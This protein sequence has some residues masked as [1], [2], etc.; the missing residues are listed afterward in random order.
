M[1]NLLLFLRLQHVTFIWTLHHTMTPPS[2]YND[3]ELSEIRR[4]FPVFDEH[5]FLNAASMTPLPSPSRD[6]VI[7]YM[8]DHSK[9]GFKAAME[10]FPLLGD[11]R[12]RAAALLGASRDEITFVRNTSDG[13][14]LV[15]FGLSFAPGDQV[16]INDQEFPSNVYPWLAL[17]EKGVE[18]V[19]VKSEE[20]RVTPEMIEAAM[21]EK[22]RLVAISSVQF[23]SGYRADLAAISR[24]CRQNN[25]Y[26]F[27][28]A[29][30]SLGLIPLDAQALGVDFLSAGAHK[31]LCGLEGA[32]IFYCAKKHIDK[33]AVTR[34]GW[35]TVKD[36]MDFWTIDY[37]LADGLDR[38]MEGSPNFTGIMALGS[39]LEVVTQRGVDNNFA[40]VSTLV[41][42]L[43][44]G[45]NTTSLSIVSPV[46]RQEERSGIVIFTSGDREADEK[47]AQRLL[48][49]SFMIT[50]QKNET[51]NIG[52]RISPHFFNTA[53]DI[54][55]LLALLD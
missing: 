41:D 48:E 11:T 21:T 33:L 42:Q 12:D 47:I 54:D 24:L 39:S 3:L 29:I 17:R 51:K 6:C 4:L 30:Q 15:A 55:R 1:A 34:A 35:H 40:H 32:G 13:I 10:R 52:I 25:A 38:F 9:R 44:R 53:T 50:H 18:I 22:T 31:W 16:I 43:I 7:D 2:P 26:L 5:I 49:R 45:L 14:S 20:G 36:P 37:T 46:E 19:T 28:D 23:S 27:V 8:E